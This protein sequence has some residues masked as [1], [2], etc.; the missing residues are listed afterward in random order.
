M[1]TALLL[2]GATTTISPDFHRF[3][4][5]LLAATHFSTLLISVAMIQ[6][7]YNEIRVISIFVDGVT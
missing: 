5:K 1:D 6:H 2:H 4:D 7:W 3:K